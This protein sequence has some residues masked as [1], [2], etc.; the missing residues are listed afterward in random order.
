MMH[1]SDALKQ[2]ILDAAKAKPSPPRTP[3]TMGGVLRAV[4]ALVAMAAIF[5]GTG[6]LDRAPGRPTSVHAPLVAGTV[7]I[8]VL[9]SFMVLPRRNSMLPRS[10]TQLLTVA[11]FVPLLI[12]AWIMIW[13]GSYDDPFQRLGV[14]CF[15]MTLATAPWPLAALMYWRDRIDP[16]HAATSGAATGAAAGA[17]AAAM[18]ELWCPLADPGHVLRGHVLPLV[19]L[20]ALG[21][22]FGA[23]LFGL[24]K[25]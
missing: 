20:T 15:L 7:A 14:R 3:R 19:A 9:A 8:A 12:G 22:L 6:G 4:M 25:R 1:P 10:R 21:A 18:V 13:H 23:R 17:W 24:R 11:V 2:R 16:V 5:V